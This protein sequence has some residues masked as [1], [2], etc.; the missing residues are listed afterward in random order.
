MV[1][2]HNYCTVWQRWSKLPDSFSEI[3][4]MVE[5]CPRKFVFFRRFMAARGRHKRTWP[6]CTYARETDNM[7]KW[8]GKRSRKSSLR[9]RKREKSWFLTSR[10][11]EK[12]SW[13][14]FRIYFNKTWYEFQK[15]SMYSW[16]KKNC[17][18][19]MTL[20]PTRRKFICENLIKSWV[21]LGHGGFWWKLKFFFRIYLIMNYAV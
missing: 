15:D 2:L 6:R 7:V 9:E 16:L 14:F 13:I 8:W 20:Q 17:K 3:R 18:E 19:T 1:R 4:E 21:K 5:E 11:C 10:V 12:S